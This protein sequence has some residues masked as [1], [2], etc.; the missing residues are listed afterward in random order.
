M[1]SQN[2]YKGQAIFIPGFYSNCWAQAL[3]NMFNQW[4]MVL[5]MFYDLSQNHPSFNLKHEARKPVST[6]FHPPMLPVGEIL[7]TAFILIIVM[8]L[9]YCRDIWCDSIYVGIF[10]GFWRGYTPKCHWD[11]VE[12]SENLNYHLCAPL[13]CQFKG[14]EKKGEK[15]RGKQEKLSHLMI[16]ARLL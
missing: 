6:T 3:C 7:G 14:E 2:D 13:H 15:K 11:S 4:L 10:D 12:A 9:K 16:C 5:D 8:C 1:F